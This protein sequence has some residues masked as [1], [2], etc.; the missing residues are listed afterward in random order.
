[1]A[2]DKKEPWLNYLALATVILA[3]CATLS[4][5]KGGG[6]STRSVMSQSQAS[7]QWAFFQAKSIKS[8][9]YQMQ[10]ENLELKLLDLN[11][12][13]AKATVNNYLAKIDDYKKKIDKYDQEK[14][15]IQDKAKQLESVRDEAQKHSQAFGMA[16]IFLQIAILL[17]SIAA[18]LKK[19]LVWY[20][21]LVTGAVG[22]FYFVDGFLL[23]V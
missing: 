18:L 12:G 21:G 5:F 20:G 22:L 9:M 13:A 23:F 2:E 10:K 8:Y 19:K 6:Y 3:V 16:I 17:S 7:D 1:M 15:E 14:T 4:T 11:R